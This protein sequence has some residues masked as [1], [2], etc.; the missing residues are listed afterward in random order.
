[1]RFYCGSPLVSSSGHRLGTLCFAD[2]SPRVFDAA[3]MQILVNLS[4]IVTRE[5]ERD[6]ALAQQAAAV[7][8]QPYSNTNGGGGGVVQQYRQHL[9]RTVECVTRCV[10][11]MLLPASAGS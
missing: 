3:S 7:A 2:S 11:V 10:I 4:E 6:V 8:Q 5:L 9:L 1:V